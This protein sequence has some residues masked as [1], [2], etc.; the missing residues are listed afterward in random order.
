[1]I[2]IYI[3]IKFIPRIDL[4]TLKKD[5][6]EGLK[7]SLPLIFHNLSNQILNVADRYMLSAWKGTSEVAIYSFSYNLGSIINMIWL[8]INNA[9]IPWYFDQLKV[10]NYLLIKEYS[11]QYIIFFMWLTTSFLLISPELVYIMGGKQYM[12]GIYIVPLIALG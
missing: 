9:W 8:S 4:G 12:N 3:C 2:G 5:W 7:L 6:Y 1:M 11:K 10:K